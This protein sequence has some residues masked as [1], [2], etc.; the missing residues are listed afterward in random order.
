MALYLNRART[1]LREDPNIKA[2]VGFNEWDESIGVTDVPL[3]P[4]SLW[5]DGCTDWWSCRLAVPEGAR[6]LDASFHNG[7]GLWENN[8]GSDFMALCR[9][10]EMHEVR[11]VESMETSELAGGTL[12][13]CKLKRKN[14]ANRRD[15]WMQEKIVRVWAPKVTGSAA[16]GTGSCFFRG[17]GAVGVEGEGK[18]KGFAAI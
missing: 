8:G 6:Q 7:V 11:E 5:R 3:T 18:G 2:H 9:R 15:K 13:V 16:W 17:V 1:A 4:T 10:A 14:A 12:H